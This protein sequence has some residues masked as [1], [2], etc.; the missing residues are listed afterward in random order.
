MFSGNDEGFLKVLVSARDL[1]DDDFKE[2][3]DRA[4]EIVSEKEEV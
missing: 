2:V 1:V 3:F 4:I